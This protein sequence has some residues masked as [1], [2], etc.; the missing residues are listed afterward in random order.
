[1]ASKRE[2][3]RKAGSEQIES[4]ESAETDSVEAVTEDSEG[5]AYEAAALDSEETAESTA[6]A[7]ESFG[8]DSAEGEEQEGEESAGSDDASV[9]TCPL[10]AKLAA[11]LFVAPRPMTVEQLADAASVK[12]ETVERELPK[13]QER[14]DADIHGFSLH[15]VSGAWQLRTHPGAAPSIQRMIPKSARRLSRAAA[16]TLAVVAYRQ[17]VQ[18]AEIET[19]RGVD[20]LPTIKTLMDARL[21]RIVGRGEA[22]GQ[23]ALYGTTEAFLEKFGLNDLTQLPSPRELAELMKEPGDLPDDDDVETLDASVEVIA[24]SESAVSESAGESDESAN[25]E[26]PAEQVPLESPELE[27][28]AA[29]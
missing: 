29:E 15:N 3:K 10:A 1:M 22:V 14:F 11:L 4:N 23:P 6:A 21:I 5:G 17:P 16:E 13:V 20:A 2:A 28:A 7:D 19:I 12:P 25:E 9:P 18:R 24:V 27:A 8:A 26:I